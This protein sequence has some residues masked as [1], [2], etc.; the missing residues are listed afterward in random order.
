MYDQAPDNE[1]L[2]C[3]KRN[4]LIFICIAIAFQSCFFAFL[5]YESLNVTSADVQKKFWVLTLLKGV[6]LLSVMWI[7]GYA[8]Q[9]YKVKVSYTRKI[10]HVCFFSI[11]FVI[12]IY[13]MNESKHS[14]IFSL[15]NVH[16]IFWLLLLIT[17]PI[18]KLSSIIQ[19]MYASSDRPVD[20]GLT[21]VYAT[22]QITLS[23]FVIAVFSI[24]Y[25]DSS[26]TLI[27]IPILSVGI[28][29]GLAEPVRTIVDDYL[30]GAHAFSVNGLFSGNRTF[31]RSLEGCLTVFVGT[32]SSIM[33]FFN[34]LNHSQ[35]IFLISVLPLTMTILEA[36]APHSMDNAILL[37]WGNI[38][39]YTSCII[40]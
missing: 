31:D 35:M 39:V 38:W 34:K 15:W 32:L 13:L 4:S 25:E 5:L 24:M 29:D 16:I 3:F 28:G 27:F 7:C 8:V 6:L 21:Q 2:L 17:K 40:F 23:I 10:V 14:W 20:R 18:R 30:W 19:T 9:N 12:D 37:L 36:V 26:K 33:L 22:I 11:P 1:T